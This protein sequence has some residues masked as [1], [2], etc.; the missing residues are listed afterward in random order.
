MNRL[1]STLKRLMYAFGSSVKGKHLRAFLTCNSATRL[2]NLLR[3][4]LATRLGRTG[5]FGYPYILTVEPTN[6]CNLQCPLCPTGKGLLGRPHQ[7]LTLESY[8]RVIDEI[9][10]Y[11]YLVNLTNWGEPLLVREIVEMIRYSHEQRIFTAISTNGNYA[12]SLNAKLV[13]AHLDHM[14]VAI[15]GSTQELY[16]QYRVGGR[17]DR[18]ADN[19]SALV[20]EKKR[21]GVA[22]PFIELQFL[23]FDHNRHDVP[24]IEALAE[25]LGVDGLL[26]RAANS[27]VNEENRRKFYTWN[28]RKGFCS[29][30]WYTA[31]INSDGGLTPCCNYFDKSDDYGNVFETSF[32]EAWN[33][34]AYRR[35]RRAAADRDVD[36]L[37]S[38]CRSCKVY[39]TEQQSYPIYTEGSSASTEALDES[40]PKPP[41]SE[42]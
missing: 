22:H 1:D 2:S 18:V 3:V 33:G 12:A 42:A 24:E 40:E 39:D 28:D 31:T 8:K 4:E 41:A 29:R 32:A 34:E 10:A 35:N 21:L 23:V 14:T 9:G 37:T 5:Y 13:D 7:A 19:V 20:A 6:V 25:R 17:L 26:I 16:E 27:P 30:F 36:E 38:I 15:D 11:L